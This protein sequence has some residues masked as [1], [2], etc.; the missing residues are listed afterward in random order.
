MKRK[1]L[2]AGILAFF[3]PFSMI[4]VHSLAQ[5]GTVNADVLNIRSLASTSSDIVAKLQEGTVLEIISTEGDWFRVETSDGI[6]GYVSKDYVSLNPAYYGTVTA[7]SLMVRS[8]TGTNSPIITKLPYGTIVELLAYD[9]A[10]YK[11][12]TA[13]GD[14]GY[15][16]ADYII[17]TDSDSVAP[18]E[19]ATQADTSQTEEVYDL[20]HGF[21]S[22]DLTRLH[23]S[24]GE[25]S[26]V[27]ALLTK[28]EKLTFL[29]YDG[30]WYK[31]RRENGQEGYVS[32]YFV[33]LSYDPAAPSFDCAIPGFVD[34]TMLNVRSTPSTWGTV[35]TGVSMGTQLD[36]L[37][38]D[39]QWYKAR[40]SDGRFGYVSGDYI[41]L[42]PV[43]YTPVTP[44]VINVTYIPKVAP[45]AETYRLGSEIITTAYQ[46]MG[47]PYRYATEGPDTFDCS[48]FT[49]YVMGFHGIN[50]P[51][52]SRDQYYCGF[53]VEKDE[54]IAGDLVFFSSANTT[55]VAHV[56]IYVGNG[57]FIHASSGSA[58]S[59]TV[60]SLSADY[61]TRH[62]LGAKRVI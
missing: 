28:G 19:E 41:S 36:L 6:S 50:L 11:I 17:P 30:A 51:R 2:A 31:V 47:K 37:S 49:M 60:S 46:Y 29:A 3:L 44:P 10:W 25:Y 4:P 32:V 35:L 38:F 7:S 20:G 62:Y 12:K 1:K 61:Y 55:G 8:S 5:S 39:G 53:A 33:T 9:G 42:N 57:D 43:E 59:V 52:P 48:G 58:Y 13:E 16:S 22:C 34:A 45:T 15:V 56:G 24:T 40:L 14:F 18:K 23:E 26:T 27:T 54:L 21:V